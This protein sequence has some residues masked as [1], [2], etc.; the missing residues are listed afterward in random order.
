MSQ[1]AHDVVSTLFQRCFDVQTTFLQRLNNIV[2]LLSEFV[3][4]HFIGNPWTNFH[5]SISI[6][7]G[8][9][10]SPTLIWV[11]RHTQDFF[12]S[13]FEGCL[14]FCGHDCCYVFLQNIVKFFLQ[15][16]FCFVCR[17]RK[18]MRKSINTKRRE[19]I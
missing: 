7:E 11:R 17:S 13:K 10:K 6:V 4:K 3:Y 14:K 15:L 9:Q 16:C 19:T 8:Y 12:Y 2:G 18:L 1:K 5:P